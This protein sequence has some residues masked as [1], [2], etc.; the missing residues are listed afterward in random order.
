MLWRHIPKHIF[1]LPLK[2]LKTPGMYNIMGNYILDI[3][4]ILLLQL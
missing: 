2:R 1:L 4:S 3:S